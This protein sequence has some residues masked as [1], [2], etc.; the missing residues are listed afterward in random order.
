M[1]L[2][3]KGTFIRLKFFDEG[4]KALASGKKP[5][6]GTPA[7]GA[8]RGMV[9]IDVN[10][11]IWPCHRWSKE[12]EIDWRFGSIYEPYFNYNA[13]SII[14]QRATK[15]QLSACRKC[16]ALFLCMGGCPA[17]NIEDTGLIYGRHSTGCALTIVLSELIVRFH[18]TMLDE[19]NP[20][21][22][23]TYYKKPQ[24]FVREVTK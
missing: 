13:R 4:C 14:N 23:D 10:G 21:F 5:Q 19:K 22:M 8:G 6:P 9:L 24:R 11:D 3:R 16:K 12:R 2:F 20:I 15:K 7:C 18:N 17:E 1:E